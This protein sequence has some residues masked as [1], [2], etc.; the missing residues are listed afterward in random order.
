MVF[1]VQSPVCSAKVFEYA[2]QA[3]WKAKAMQWD[4]NTIT[5]TNHFI[6]HR[7]KKQ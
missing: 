1:K 6:L 7:I 2:G 3:E 5:N 4:L